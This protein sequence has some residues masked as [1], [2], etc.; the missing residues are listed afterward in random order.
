MSDTEFS[1][2]TCLTH[3]RELPC[4]RCAY[5]VQAD[6]ADTLAADADKIYPL[7]A[8]LAKGVENAP[9]NFPPRVREALDD[10][11]TQAC[12]VAY[13]LRAATAIYRSETKD[14]KNHG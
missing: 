5:E 4:E 3:R 13:L 2:G 7:V 9:I 12:R 6:Y 11:Q 8:H 10:L 14:R 1:E